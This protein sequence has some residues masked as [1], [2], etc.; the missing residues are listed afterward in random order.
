MTK[1]QFL[2]SLAFVSVFSFVG[3][4]VGGW[5]VV[6]HFSEAT[7]K[8]YSIEAM[9]IS[10]EQ[11][12]AKDI[13]LVNDADEIIGRFMSHKNNPVF[14][15]YSQKK[16]CTIWVKPEEVAKLSGEKLYA[17]Q[18]EVFQTPYF[19]ITISEDEPSVFLC[20]KD[21]DS[22]IEIGIS[23]LEPG[24][25]VNYNKKTR[26]R[27]GTNNLLHPSTGEQRKLLGSIVVW[28]QNGKLS[29]MLP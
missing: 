13:C 14:G 25:S 7:E 3:G 26:L 1:R 6:P 8:P 4:I 28:D 5:F 10:A 9:R 18:R 16:P 22:R 27:I 24:I 20:D 11:I 17:H 12:L 15:M 29:G 21:Y 19:G 23:K 2:I